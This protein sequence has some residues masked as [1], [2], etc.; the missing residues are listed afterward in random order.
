MD[1]QRIGYEVTMFPVQ[2]L[3]IETEDSTI[4]SDEL[5]GPRDV[6]R[7]RATPEGVKIESSS[8]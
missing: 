4:G 2:V 8:V 3:N 1:S 7:G 5:T 6:L